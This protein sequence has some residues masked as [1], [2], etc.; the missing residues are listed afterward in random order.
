MAT[1][2]ANYTG[3]N[4]HRY[5]LNIDYS[6]DSVDTVNNTS[7]AVCTIR[8]A[9][10]NNFGYFDSTNQTGYIIIDGTQTNFNSNY[11]SS[12]TVTWTTQNKT[13]THSADGTKT[14]NIQGYHNANQGGGLGTASLNFSFPLTTIPR[15]A[16]VSSYTHSLVTDTSLRLN[17]NTDTACNLLEYS[18]NGAGYVTGYSGSFTSQTVDLTNL[19]SDTL[20]SIVVRV[21]RTDS[22]LTTTSSA[23][24]STTNKQN[25]FFGFIKK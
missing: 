14:I 24:A 9:T 17:V 16:V 10:S 2:S 15:Y 18:V 21:T 23:V 22:G 20:Y 25:N 12:G 13:V 8:M 19:L 6:E 11:S 5:T 7:R 1:A 4:G 3:T